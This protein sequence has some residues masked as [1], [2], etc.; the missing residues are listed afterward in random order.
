MGIEA[1]DVL[2]VPSRDVE[3]DL[4]FY[5]DVLGARV[6]F[7]IEAMGTR[8]AEVALAPDGP[9]VVLAGHLAGEAPVLLHRVGDLDETLAEL[10]G[11]G[12]RVEHQVELPLGPC[13]TLR[14]PGGQRI[15]FYELT[16]PQVDDHFAG[17]SDFV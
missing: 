5:R 11:R 14:T 13:A 10:E 12:A 7:A 2:Y 4:A 3:A 8:V 16:R 9:R 1:L 15:G 17:R 6:V